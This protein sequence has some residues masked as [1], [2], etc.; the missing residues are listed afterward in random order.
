MQMCLKSQTQREK[1][2]YLDNGYSRYM[3]RNKS[4]FRN[5]RSKDDGTIKFADG[6]K[7]KV[8]G[9]GNVGKNDSILINDVML[10]EGLTHNLLNISQFCDQGYKVMFEPSQCIIRDSTSDKIILTTR[11]RYN[12]DNTYVLYLDDLLDQN[13]KCLASLLD[14][15][16]LWHKKLGHAHMKLIYE[17]SH[18]ELVKGLPKI[19]F[20]N[21]SSYEFCLRGKQTKS[22]FHS[23]NVVSTTRP[24][25]LL[26]LD[27]FDPTR[28]ASLGG[29]KYGLVIMDDYSRFTWVIFLIHKDEACEAFKTF[30]KRIQNEKGFCVTIRNFL[31]SDLYC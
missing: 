17:I 7:S 14:E 19:S 1:K 16:R 18:K 30:L 21:D 3:T 31:L 28:T 8:I 29:R 24:L 26:H 5:L 23:K 9:I 15:K 22:S 6:I 20:E 2:W 12:A 25:E 27:L 11:R 10:I 4:W 13:V